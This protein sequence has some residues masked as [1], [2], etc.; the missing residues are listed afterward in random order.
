[1]L[2]LLIL[3]INVFVTCRHSNFTY[4]VKLEGFVTL[5][6]IILSEARKISWPKSSYSYRT[7]GR[8]IDVSALQVCM[9]LMFFIGDMNLNSLCAYGKYLNFNIALFVLCLHVSF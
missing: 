4:R 8:Y 9:S 6:Y 2:V 7:S 3:A 1:V 5:K